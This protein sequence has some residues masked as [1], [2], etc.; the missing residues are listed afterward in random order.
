[1]A[2]AFSVFA[3][4]VNVA[5]AAAR[6]SGEVARL[7]R[8]W[9]DAPELVLQ[10]ANEAA[11]LAVVLEHFQEAENG[12]SNER[13]VRSG[14]GDNDNNPGMGTAQKFT[15]A[16][17]RQLETAGKTL[18]ELQ[19]LVAYLQAGRS[20]PSRRKRWVARQGKAVRLKC[21]LKEAREKL[22]DHVLANEV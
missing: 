3:A 2:E 14:A 6:S 8:A 5:D 18:E 10:L 21:A 15:V 13:T 9:R 12:S 11:D 17:R 7:L 4:A 22:R 19:S 16:V 20:G 1:M